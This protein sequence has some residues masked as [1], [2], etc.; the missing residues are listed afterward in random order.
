MVAGRPSGQEVGNRSK[1]DKG[2]VTGVAFGDLGE[3][4]QRRI[5]EEM[6]KEVEEIEAVKM[7]EKLACYQKTRGSVVQKADTGE[8]SASKVSAQPL[9]PEEL[10]HLVDISIASKYGTDLAQLTHILAEDVRH[11]LDCLDMI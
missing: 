10:A 4:D 8:A 1:A 6:R 3:A 7:R 5:G 9:P 11:T 2:N